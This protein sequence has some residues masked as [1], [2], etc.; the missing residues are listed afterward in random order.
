[1][2]V[3]VHWRVMCISPEPSTTV[4]LFLVHSTVGLG[5]PTASQRRV[6]VALTL[7][8][9]SVKLL[10]ILAAS[11]PKIKIKVSK[12]LKNCKSRFCVFEQIIVSKLVLR[13]KKIRFQQFSSVKFTTLNTPKAEQHIFL[14]YFLL[15]CI[16]LHLILMYSVWSKDSKTCLHTIPFIFNLTPQALSAT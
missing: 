6:M 12:R 14:F 8:F 7:T 15:L 1:M 16:P 13:Y 2:W 10:S 3:S 9:W 5:I 11:R 4:W